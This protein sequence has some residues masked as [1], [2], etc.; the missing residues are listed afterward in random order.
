MLIASL[1]YVSALI[2]FII[3]GLGIVIFKS[4]PSRD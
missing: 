4:G 2:A 3:V 1:Y